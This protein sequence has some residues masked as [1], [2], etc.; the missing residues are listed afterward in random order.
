MEIYFKIIF[1]TLILYILIFI[2]LRLMGKREIGELSIL[3]VVVFIM[4]AEMAALAIEKNDTPI[5][6]TIIPIV[7]LTAIQI[8]SAFLSLK[9]QRF[10]HF[11]DGRPTVII[12]EGQ[13]DENA[14]RSQRYNFDD[15][16]LQLREKDI[17]DI[18]DVDFAILETSGK[19]SVIKKDKKN[20]NGEITIPLIMDGIIQ[21]D[22]LAKKNRDENWLIKQ[23]KKRGYHNIED[24]SFCSF[25]QGKFFI[26][27]KDKKK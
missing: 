26:D 25:Q 6:Q 16:L 8:F 1:R 3:D 7:L 18:A 4:I 23:L 10:R 12:N 27:L 14:M 22:N 13:I 11:M 21:H 2:I 5:L 15:L 19:L 20:K 17:K 9:S 24:I